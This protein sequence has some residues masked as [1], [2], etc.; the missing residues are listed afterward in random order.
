MDMDIIEVSEE[1]YDLYSRI[2]IKYEVMS[3]YRLEYIDN[4]MDGSKFIEEKVWINILQNNPQL[5]VSKNSVLFP[6]GSR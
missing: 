2:P 5:N 4:G 1:G 6:T 3:K